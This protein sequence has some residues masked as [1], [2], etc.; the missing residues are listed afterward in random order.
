MCVLQ[1][2][3][4]EAGQKFKTSTADMCVCHVIINK[5]PEV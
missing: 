3:T 4:Y 1:Q 2:G 5:M